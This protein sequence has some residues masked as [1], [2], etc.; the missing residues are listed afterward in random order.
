M[1]MQPQIRV[2]QRPRQLSVEWQSVSFGVPI[3]TY[4][5]SASD[6]HPNKSTHAKSDFPVSLLCLELF[7]CRANSVSKR[8]ES[9]R[10]PRTL[11]F[12]RLQQLSARR[13]VALAAKV[14]RAAVEGLRARR[15]S[16]GLLGLPRLAR[17]VWRS[18]LFRA[19]ARLRVRVEKSLR[20]YA[21]LRTRR[22]GVARLVRS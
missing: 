17:S 18:G 14:E 3:S 21:G 9:H 1:T 11:H 7:E 13:S 22:E 10:T 2:P 20:L 19:S 15:V 6:D 12:G 5:K 8:H 16:R 4:R